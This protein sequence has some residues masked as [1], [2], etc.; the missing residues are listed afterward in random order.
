MKC[1]HIGHDKSIEITRYFEDN[2][3]AEAYFSAKEIPRSQKNTSVKLIKEISYEEISI[4]KRARKIKSIF[5][6]LCMLKIPDLQYRGERTYEN[7]W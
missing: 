7:N 2:S 5:K 6:N 1:G 4:R 3:I